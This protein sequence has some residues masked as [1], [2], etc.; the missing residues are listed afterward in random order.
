M[1]RSDDEA[2]KERRIAREAAA[3]R[4]DDGFFEAKQRA[5]VEAVAKIT[6]LREQRLAETTNEPAP[7]AKGAAGRSRKTTP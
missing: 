2:V 7:L 1:A 4:R 6:R 3:K 5:H